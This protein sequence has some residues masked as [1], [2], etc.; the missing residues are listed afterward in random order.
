MVYSWSFISYLI[1]GITKISS[2]LPDSHVKTPTSVTSQRNW[3]L[4]NL[5][6][7]FAVASSIT[8][9]RL[10]LKIARARHTSCRWPTLKF[11]PDSASCS[12]SLFGNSSTAC[13]SWTWRTTFY[14]NI[15]RHYSNCPFRHYTSVTSSNTFHSSA[16]SRSPNGSKFLLMGPL[17]KTGSYKN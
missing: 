5:W 13:F 14:V 15:C 8:K 9:I 6:S 16:S 4:T 2:M 3:T 12:S 17:N 11:E 1:C 7:T 10:W